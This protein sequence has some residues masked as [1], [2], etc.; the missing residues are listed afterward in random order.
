MQ[1][2]RVLQSSAVC[3]QALVHAGSRHLRCASLERSGGGFIPLDKSNSTMCPEARSEFT[4]KY[5]GRIRVVKNTVS[6]KGATRIP[7]T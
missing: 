1:K 6:S 4:E 2:Q 7:C 5:V 3:S